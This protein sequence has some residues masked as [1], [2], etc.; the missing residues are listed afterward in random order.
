[1]ARTKQGRKKN[2]TNVQN[3]IQQNAF[4]PSRDST[5]IKKKTHTNKAN[6]P[7]QNPQK[8]NL[9]RGTIWFIVQLSLPF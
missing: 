4:Q 3:K 1:M 5:Q 6:H 7:P 8:L 2:E 9:G